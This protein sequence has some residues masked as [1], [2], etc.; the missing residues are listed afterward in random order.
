MQCWPCPSTDYFASKKRS[1]RFCNIW[2]YSIFVNK[3]RQYIS[4]TKDILVN[5]NDTD[6]SLEI[7]KEVQQK[8]IIADAVS[9][10]VD[11]CI[12]NDILRDFFEQHRQEV[13][14]MGILGY[15]AEGHMEGIREEGVEQGY[16]E[17]KKE[18]EIII[19][20]SPDIFCPGSLI[21]FKL[22]L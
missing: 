4:E 11:Y 9:K 5:I 3:V 7:D 1:G 16:D 6:I 12:D 2:G 22:Y 17:A 21:L 19:T 14:D 8:N 13:I 10:A 15:T 18:D 20:K